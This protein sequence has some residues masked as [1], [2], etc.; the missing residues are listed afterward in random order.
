M[1]ASIQQL[2]RAAER[3]GDDA[4][5]ELAN[6]LAEKDLIEPQ[7]QSPEGRGNQAD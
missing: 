2:A 4:A 3:R 6:A 5:A 7:S 1:N